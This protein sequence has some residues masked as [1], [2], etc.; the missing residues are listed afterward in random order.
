MAEA[1]RGNLSPQCHC[2]APFASLAVTLPA[3]QQGASEI[4]MMMRNTDEQRGHRSVQI[5]TMRQIRDHRGHAIYSYNS[6]PQLG[7]RF[8]DGA[9]HTPEQALT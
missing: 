7:D 8:C 1:A 4:T 2:Q 5:C 9:Q 6:K 3:T